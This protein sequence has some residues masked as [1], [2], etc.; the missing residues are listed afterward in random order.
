MI[1]NENPF[2]NPQTYRNEILSRV[3]VKSCKSNFSGKSFICVSLTKFCPV[4]C[5]F[6]FFS[7]PKMRKNKTVADAFNGEGIEKFIRFANESNLGYLLVSGG[8]EPFIE[9]NHLLKV[10]EEVE[11]D[12]IVLVT[13]GN[14]AKSKDECLAFV[15]KIYGAFRRRKVP[16]ELVIRLSVDLEHRTVGLN[17]A[18]FLIS[19]FEDNY[20]REK[21][22]KLQFHTLFGDP[23]VDQVLETLR[24]KVIEI[25]EYERQSDASTIVKVNPAEKVIVFSSGLVLKV[26]YAKIFYSNLKVDLKN[27]EIL[28][29]N[30]EVFMKDLTESEQCNPSRVANVNGK[31]GLDFWVNYNGNVTTWGNQSP[32]NLYN[33]YEDSYQEVVERTFSDPISLF[34]LEKEDSYRDSIIQEVN[35]IAVLRAKA[36]NVRDF[37]SSI[38]LQEEKTR[39][40]L[41]LR[42]LQ[43]LI[44]EGKVSEAEIN[45][46]PEK[47]RRLVKSNKN[48]LISLYKCSNHCIIDQYMKEPAF[49]NGEWLDLFDVIKLGHYEVSDEKLQIGIRFYNQHATEKHIQ[50]IREIGNRSFSSFYQERITKIKDSVS[51]RLVLQEKK[52]EL[53]LALVN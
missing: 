49:N 32:D 53:E 16:T 18:Y 23:S 46:W 45:Q 5:K 51:K 12:K 28:E 8:G 4:G 44:K 22:F 42:V 52:E 2:L 33:I 13:S 7:S 24:S 3:R 19:I 38:L 39:L 27:S 41:S 43:E 29:R 14:W 26:G 15:Q 48:E 30:L 31:N 25:K 1:E 21:N 50:N 37:T 35:P 40:Y 20:L 11:S 47:I 9:K 34:Y 36:T 10:V 6:C 17:P